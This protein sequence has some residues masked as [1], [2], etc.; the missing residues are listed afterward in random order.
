MMAKLIVLACVA[1]A[2][3]ANAHWT[4]DESLAREIGN[5]PG[6]EDVDV[7]GLSDE[8]IST[9]EGADEDKTYRVTVGT[10]AK[11]GSTSKFKIWL[12]GPDNAEP[13]GGKHLRYYQGPVM[14]Y[15]LAE[16]MAPAFRFGMT[17]LIDK[18]GECS[19]TDSATKM[20]KVCSP[21]LAKEL[22]PCEPNGKACKRAIEDGG[23]GYAQGP[24]TKLQQDTSGDSYVETGPIQRGQVKFA[25]VGQIVEVVMKEDVVWSGSNKCYSMPG[26]SKRDCSSPWSPSFVKI[27]TNDPKT[28]IGNGVYYVKPRGDLKVGTYGIK[29][30]GNKLVD[31]TEDLKAKPADP[32]TASGLP[33]NNSFNAVLTKC[34]AQTCEEEMDTKFGM[35]DMKDEF[36]M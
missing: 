23:V 29:G 18:D 28:G 1:L 22:D 12:K 6:E 11:G 34:V 25:N 5:P 21:T 16:E 30:E 14:S 17:P 20:P 3:V 2:M 7:A 26:R 9:T 36:G 27:S 19:G 24:V 33:E 32:S 10:R 31:N 35:M 15:E 8:L 4:H 13:V